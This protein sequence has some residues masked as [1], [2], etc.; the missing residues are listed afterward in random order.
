MTKNMFRV[1]T[2]LCLGYS[3]S[4]K[5]WQSF[6]TKEKVMK[7]N[8]F[9]MLLFILSICLPVALSGLAVAADSL[10][11]PSTINVVPNPKQEQAGDTSPVSQVVPQGQQTSPMLCP[12]M[13]MGTM[14]S[15]GSMGHSM[16][17]GE[18]LTLKD[19]LTYMSMNDILQLLSDMI[20]VQEKM[21]DT[22]T[23]QE[24]AALKK[25]L[26]GLKDKTEKLILENRSMISGRSRD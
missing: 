4:S 15:M 26:M 19:I 7:K 10:Q 17:H 14:C 11:Q 18:E 23:K 16:D 1:D 6:N 5:K 21:A 25:E 22:L 3:L 20:R 12:M 2:I 9:A 24:R 8:L 13:P